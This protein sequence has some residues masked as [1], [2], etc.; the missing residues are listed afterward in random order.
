LVVTSV[1]Q[2][3]ECGGTS[4]T[5]LDS[6]GQPVAADDANLIE[7]AKQLRPTQFFA[8]SGFQFLDGSFGVVG[9]GGANCDLP[10]GPRPGFG[11]VERI[12]PDGSL[13]PNYGSQGHAYFRAM[14][15]IEAWAVP[16]RQGGVVVVGE[17]FGSITSS[18]SILQLTGI[19]P[20]GTL[21]RHFGRRGQTHLVSPSGF[22]G[23]EAVTTGPRGD[24]VLV[25][26]SKRG[27]KVVFLTA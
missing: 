14:Q 17:E 16:T 5:M 19:S 3:M 23:D 18:S 11:L 25:L 8:G 15:S 26:G 13:D 20:L 27:A 21:D 6:S 24:V 10:P 12:L 7:T 1:N 2:G 22:F 9:T 4:M